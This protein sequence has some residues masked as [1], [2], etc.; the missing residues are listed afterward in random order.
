MRTT[1]PIVL[2]LFLASLPAC[3]NRSVRRAPDLTTTRPV[4]LD[5]EKPNWLQ[6]TSDATW[7]AV[8]APAKL[9]TPAPAKKPKPP[10]EPY[11]P[12][13]ATIISRNAPL[14]IETEPASTL[15]ATQP[16]AHPSP[17]QN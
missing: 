5:P 10:V 6:R 3:T 2:L 13:D 11:E 8:Q 17:N 15:P 4:A 16:T 9:L 14:I 12:A 1:L 7:S